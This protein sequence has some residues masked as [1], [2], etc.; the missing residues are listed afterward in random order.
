MLVGCKDYSPMVILPLM[1]FIEAGGS[2]NVVCALA[3][4][5]F[6]VGGLSGSG[7]LLGPSLI[8]T[9]CWL[10]K[11]TKAVGPAKSAF[12]F[13]PGLSKTTRTVCGLV[14]SRLTSIMDH[15]PSGRRSA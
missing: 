8:H 13:W 6:A 11:V 5:V 14:S 3:S 15:F 12:L 4:K 7:W 2:V 9:Y 1:T 10:P